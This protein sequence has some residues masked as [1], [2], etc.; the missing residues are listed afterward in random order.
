MTT[1]KKNIDIDI[2]HLM[3]DDWV[4]YDGRPCQIRT[5]SSGVGVEPGGEVESKKIYPLPINENDIKEIS[6]RIK[7]IEGYVISCRQDGTTGKLIV[8]LS[9]QIVGEP[10]IYLSRPIQYYHQLQHLIHESDCPL[11]INY[12]WTH[13]DNRGEGSNE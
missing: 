4:L 8:D 1:K 13:E 12:Y 5:V 6:K 10:M 11:L 2:R 3:I 9:R 7:R